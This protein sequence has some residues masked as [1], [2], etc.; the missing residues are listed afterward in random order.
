MVKFIIVALNIIIN[1]IAVINFISGMKVYQVYISSKIL[2]IEFYN[3]PSI[4]K[5]K[6]S[7]LYT[8]AF[9]SLLPYTLLKTE[10]FER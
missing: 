2:N 9:M 8:K 1:I 4:K 5:T 3:K 7:S 6:S 10:C